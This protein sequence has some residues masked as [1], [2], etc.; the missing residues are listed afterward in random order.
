MNTSYT[1]SAKTAKDSIA[2]HV[3]AKLKPTIAEKPVSRDQAEQSIFEA[4]GLPSGKR[5]I[6]SFISGILAG[7]CTAYLGTSLITY[8]AVGCAVLTGSAFLTFMLMFIGYV[9]AILAT[10]LVGGKV[11]AFIL[12]GDIDRCYQKYSDMVGNTLGSLKNKIVR[13]AA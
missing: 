8:L 11:Q 2:S 4:L 12:S 13:V 7:G 5:V 9:I 1:S 3:R 10:G 6:V